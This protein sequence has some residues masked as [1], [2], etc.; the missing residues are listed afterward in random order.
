MEKRCL[1][2]IDQ[3]DSKEQLVATQ[4][5]DYYNDI[6]NGMFGKGE[7]W[8]AE[9][10]DRDVYIRQI[11]HKIDKCS[12]E[13]TMLGGGYSKGRTYGGGLMVGFGVSIGTMNVGASYTQSKK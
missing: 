3:K 6:K 5:F 11:G 10:D 7:Q 2:S 4:S 9:Q 13:L 1:K 12:D 8:T